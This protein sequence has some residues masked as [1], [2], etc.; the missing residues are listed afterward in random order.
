MSIARQRSCKHAC[1]TKED[2][3]LSGVRAEEVSW[4]QSAL[5][6]SQF[7]AGES[8]GKFVIEEELE[9]DLWRRF[10]L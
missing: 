5:A 7:S 4:R 3:V 10:V 1:L 8:H 2:D 9:V 6:V